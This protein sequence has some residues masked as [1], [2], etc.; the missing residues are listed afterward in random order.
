MTPEQRE[1]WTRIE[2]FELDVPN[3][4]LPFSRRLARENGWSADFTQ[5]AIAEYKRFVFLAMCADH[6]VAPSEEVD[7]VW[8]FHLTYTRSYWDE[9][10]GQ[11]LPRPLHHGPT[12]GGKDEGAKF[13]DLYERTLASYRRCF[14][15]DAPPD[16]WP[17]AHVRFGKAH[18]IRVDV[19]GN[20]VIGKPRWIKRP[21]STCSAL[22]P[23]NSTS[24]TR[25]GLAFVAL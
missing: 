25:W 14:G 12:R 19:Q 24:K 22:K 15:E 23:A 21:A 16:L 17:S 20:W 6:I 1:L 3:S 10:C 5:R 11:V 13:H 4:A 18:W 7:Q 8:H 9:L 2:D